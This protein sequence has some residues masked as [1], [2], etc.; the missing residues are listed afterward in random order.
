MQRQATH[1]KR[2]YDLACARF[3]CSGITVVGTRNRAPTA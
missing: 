2:M 1:H 3:S